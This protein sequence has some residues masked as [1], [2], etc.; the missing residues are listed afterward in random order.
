L[1]DPGRERRWVD[2]DELAGLLLAGRMAR[3]HPRLVEDPERG[4]GLWSTKPLQ[5][6][7]VRWRALP[8]RILRP[9][10]RSSSASP[11]F[12]AWRDRLAL[13][14]GVE[15]EAERVWTE[16]HDPAVHGLPAMHPEFQIT[17]IQNGAARAGRLAA[18][19]RRQL[20]RPRGECA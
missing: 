9:G 20:A 3:R 1:P 13:W 2:G 4:R 12:A 6:D 15:V 5:P 14:L 19:S 11:Q 10:C 18:A 17:K 16:P 8:A 7:L